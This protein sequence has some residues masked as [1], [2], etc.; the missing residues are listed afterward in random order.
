[1][2][3]LSELD[4]RLAE[5]AAHLPLAEAT[6]DRLRRPRSS[7]QVSLPVRGDDG[8]VRSYPGYRVRWDVTR[9][10]GK[11]GVRFHPSVDRAG[12][13]RLALGMTVKTALLDLPYG[14]AK[15]GVRIDPKAVST[16]E[17][18]RV[19]RAW[20]SGTAD[21]LGP[22]RDIPAPDLYTNERVMAW[23][24]DQWTATV[25]RHQP[26]AF[27][28][29]PLALGG[30]HGRA[31]ATADGAK[32]VID[33][34]GTKLDLSGTPPTV[35]VQ[36]F[37]NAGAELAEQ[38]FHAGWRVVAVSDSQGG[39]LAREGLDIPRVRRHKDAGRSL[40]GVICT[41]SVC[42]DP[43][44]DL[45]EPGELLPLDVD[46]LVPAALGAAITADNAGD[47]SARVIV[48][49]ANGPVTADADAILAARGVTV[50]PDV[51][52]SSG[53]VTVSYFEWVQNRQGLRWSPEEVD[54]RLGERLRAAAEETWSRAEDLGAP[55]RTAASALALERL[56]VA[57]RA[58][59]SLE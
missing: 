34:L 44:H 56:D 7:L 11:G 25:R 38:L 29:K 58:R 19:A 55:L 39:I 17:I 43:G 1:M 32:H 40:D 37:G 21:V 24:V 57:A 35:A 33:A 15:G 30:S 23:M 6:L 8:Q 41:G 54:R 28:G 22:E 14:G 45:L 59:D 12:V 42:D 31:T 48:E 5:A 52:A 4:P 53:G 16:A 2:P 9:G 51:L 46:L 18:E 26:A 27:T 50:V 47:V 36:G 49:V 13:E 10:P 20:V 3:D